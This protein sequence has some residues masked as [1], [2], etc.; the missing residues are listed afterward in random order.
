MRNQGA[1]PD[2][3]LIQRVRRHAAMAVLFRSP[4]DHLL[5]GE[6]VQA[7][8]VIAAIT[9]GTEIEGQGQPV[10]ADQKQPGAVQMWPALQAK[11]S[12]T[13]GL[14]AVPTV[15]RNLPEATKIPATHSTDVGQTALTPFG[16][17]TE[18][19]QRTGVQPPGPEQIRREPQRQTTTHSHSDPVWR[20]L[21]AIYRKHQEVAASE[22]PVVTEERADSPAP[23][24][25]LE[26]NT[27]TP[28]VD[29][30]ARHLPG[31]TT[32][33]NDVLAA[34]AAFGP[35]LG[36]PATTRSSETEP[37]SDAPA[38]PVALSPANSGASR[39]SNTRL[40]TVQ[41]DTR[42]AE[43]V[44]E[45][46]ELPESTVSRATPDQMRTTP[47]SKDTSVQL[48]P[49]DTSPAS[50]PAVQP[51][52]LGTRPVAAVSR[53]SREAT[54]ASPTPVSVP[55]GRQQITEM[56][57]PLSTGEEDQSSALAQLQGT[58]ESQDKSEYGV[59]P[60]TSIAP[61][62]QIEQLPASQV[63]A[64]RLPRQPAP[65]EAVWPVQR[66]NDAA[67]QPATEFTPK[68]A[69]RQP[70][71]LAKN[72]DPAM[73][74]LLQALPTARPTQSEI[75]LLPP[76]TPRP[77]VQRSQPTAEA[78][79]S[80]ESSMATAPPTGLPT[81]PTEETKVAPIMVETAIGALPGDLWELI[82]ESPPTRAVDVADT[83]LASDSAANVDPGP[84]PQQWQPAEELAGET[85]TTGI[86]RKPSAPD[87]E[88][89][90]P[91][92]RQAGGNVAEA[93]ELAQSAVGETPAPSVDVTGT[94]RGGARDEPTIGLDKVAEVIQ[95]SPVRS[96]KTGSQRPQIIAWEADATR[97]VAQRAGADQA[98]APP[99][100]STAEET[101]SPGQPVDINALAAEVYTVIRR[102]LSVEWERLRDR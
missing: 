82:G 55:V 23:S 2:N 65:L 11:E 14:G 63:D 18:P 61:L 45:H 80:S 37:A 77:P 93:T 52:P 86:Y 43:T 49:E 92:S 5:S 28:I 22:S 8:N 33:V 40:T 7:P 29:S 76:R 25:R 1:H 70:Q 21:Q 47:G 13:S 90:R 19:E 9:E 6:V 51:A 24:P 64:D 66:R 67:A 3:P 32:S 89:S 26:Q 34:S 27:D 62:P 68:G 91:L 74:N 95:R 69:T 94:P 72:D 39:S 31:E 38:V 41:P 16:A 101:A 46:S 96:D 73:H 78:A 102:R 56:S 60:G 10:A 58:R 57:E 20:R 87:R 4:A 53:A 36:P 50:S 97:S 85:P 100:E 75:E 99:T 30:P 88:Q 17:R 84:R 54:S 83:N 79:H 81:A 35:A 15:R 98:A 59:S 12:T 42:S 48:R 44:H 71:P